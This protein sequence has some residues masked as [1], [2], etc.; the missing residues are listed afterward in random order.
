MRF[1]ALLITVR[2]VAL[3]IVVRFIAFIDAARF[4][5]FCIVVS[6]VC[7]YYCSIFNDFMLIGF[8]SCIFIDIFF[9]DLRFMLLFAYLDPLCS[10]SYPLWCKTGTLVLSCACFYRRSIA[11]LTTSVTFG[12]SSLP[13]LSSFLFLLAILP[14]FCVLLLLFV[15]GSFYYTICINILLLFCL[16][17]SSSIAVGPP[18]DALRPLEELIPGVLAASKAP[19]TIKEYHS[20][21]ISKVKGMGCLFSWSLVFSCFCSSFFTLSY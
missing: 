1:I 13:L 6:S 12:P 16:F 14:V 15:I 5:S 7:C 20:Q 17:T 10:A 19:L 8:L 2:F 18:I 11:F 4:I 9:M 21:L 3:V